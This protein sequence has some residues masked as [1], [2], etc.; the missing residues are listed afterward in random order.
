MAAAVEGAEGVEGVAAVEEVEEVVEVVEEPL[1]WV[2]MCFK[3]TVG[4]ITKAP[5]G[6]DSTKMD[7]PNNG[8]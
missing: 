8:A 7:N 5:I 2:K 1:V 4:W 6:S 3:T